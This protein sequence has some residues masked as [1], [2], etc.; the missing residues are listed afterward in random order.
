VAPPGAATLVSPTGSIGTTMPA[1]TWNAVP[2]ATWYYLWVNDS[3]GPRKIQIWY[4]A[5]AAGCGSGT[6]MCSVTP[7]VALAP[8]SAIWWIQTWNDAGYGPWSTGRPFTVQ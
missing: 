7:A 6:G 8:G 5:A 2:T 4:T 1:Y 3:T